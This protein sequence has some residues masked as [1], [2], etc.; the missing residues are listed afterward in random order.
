M[1]LIFRVFYW[2]V[3]R[4]DILPGKFW[5]G[6]LLATLCFLSL[7]SFLEPRRPKILKNRH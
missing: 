2:A 6:P 1:I 5:N 3:L 7:Q 4:A